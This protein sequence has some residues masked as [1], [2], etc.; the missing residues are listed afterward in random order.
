MEMF[1]R[2]TEIVLEEQRKTL[3]H[4]GSNLPY[5]LA[6]QSVRGTDGLKA[7]PLDAEQKNL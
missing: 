6:G 7:F 5:A 2:L 1:K 4:F 3:R